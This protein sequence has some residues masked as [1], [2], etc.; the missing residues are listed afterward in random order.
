MNKLLSTMIFA[1]PV[2]LSGCTGIT[3]TMLNRS[4]SDD[5][6]V[7]KPAGAVHH[8][9]QG[10]PVT[11]D[12]YTH[13]DLRITETLYYKS[14]KHGLEPVYLGRRLLDVE[15]NP[16]LTSKVFTV[17]FKK[18]G[19]GQLNYK[20]TFD[21]QFFESFTNKIQDDTLKDITAALGTTSKVIKGIFTSSL[22]DK[23]LPKGL[24]DDLVVVK[25]HVAFKRF[26]INAPDF[27][28]SV[29]EFVN[30][31]MNSCHNCNSPPATYAR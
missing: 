5:Y 3:S 29:E 23:G 4:D 14:T 20:A 30:L 6:S 12:V 13:L 8:F 25:R 2:L 24:L 9:T 16:R 15:Q 21:E 17:D 18:P 28:K 7:N 22:S 19:A 1:L 31:H 27:E 10:I 26:D 11:V